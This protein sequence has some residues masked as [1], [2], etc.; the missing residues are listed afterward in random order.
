MKVADTCDIGL[1]DL[2]PIPCSQENN[3]NLE[4][5][6]KVLQDEPRLEEIEDASDI[7]SDLSIH[8]EI[9]NA[10]SWRR[11]SC[12]KSS[13][14]I[15]SQIDEFAN[16]EK[17]TPL[18]G[19][20]INLDGPEL[21]S[22][23]VKV[24]STFIVS[25]QENKNLGNG[26][27]NVLEPPRPTNEHEIMD[28]LF[29]GRNESE[30]ACDNLGVIDEIFSTKGASCCSQS[31]NRDEN[32]DSP[33]LSMLLSRTNS[34]PA[35]VGTGNNEASTEESQSRAGKQDSMG[36]SFLLAT[37]DSDICNTSDSSLEP[38]VVQTDTEVCDNIN[39]SSDQSNQVLLN[40]VASEVSPSRRSSVLAPVGVTFLQE[41]AKTNSIKQDL[42]QVTKM[43]FTRKSLID[44]NISKL[45]LYNS[46]KSKQARSSEMRQSNGDV[47]HFRRSS[48]FFP[49]NNSSMQ[50]ISEVETDLFV[51]SLTPFS[52]DISKARKE[53]SVDVQNNENESPRQSLRINSCSVGI[54]IDNTLTEVSGVN[55]TRD[56]LRPRSKS[57]SSFRSRSNI[58]QRNSSLSE[59]RT[60]KSGL[61][62]NVSIPE[63]NEIQTRK[64]NGEEISVGLSITKSARSLSSENA[65]SRTTN[66][67]RNSA[68]SLFAPS[69]LSIRANSEAFDAANVFA[70]QQVVNECSKSE[71]IGLFDGN[72]SKPS[73]ISNFLEEFSRSNIFE[74]SIRTNK[75]ERAVAR[76][77]SVVRKVSEATIKEASELQ[78]SGL[79]GTEGRVSLSFSRNDISSSEDARRS[80]SILSGF[81]S[82]TEVVAK[83]KPAAQPEKS[84][85]CSGSS[86][87][88]DKSVSNDTFIRR[89]INDTL[90]SRSSH[91]AE[92]SYSGLV[93]NHGSENTASPG[94][95]ESGDTHGTRNSSRST[96]SSSR[97]N[98]ASRSSGRSNSTQSQLKSFS[99]IGKGISRTPSNK[100]QNEESSLH[101]SDTNKSSLESSVFGYSSEQSVKSR[102]D[103]NV[104]QTSSKESLKESQEIENIGS[105][106]LDSTE[107]S[108]NVSQSTRSRKQVI[109]PSY[110]LPSLDSGLE[111][112]KR[113]IKSSSL[114]DQPDKS[115]LKRKSNRSEES[116]ERISQRKSRRSKSS[117]SGQGY[118][119][120]AVSIISKRKNLTKKDRSSA[121]SLFD[122][123][124]ANKTAEKSQF[125]NEL[126][127]SREFEYSIRANGN[128]RVAKT[129][130][131]VTN[132]ISVDSK[133]TSEIQLSDV[134]GTRER[135]S[136]RN[137][138]KAFDCHV[139]PYAL[140]VSDM[141]NVTENNLANEADICEMQPDEKSR[142]QTTSVQMLQNSAVEVMAAGNVDSGCQNETATGSDGKPI[143]FSDLS[144][145]SA[146]S[147]RKEI[148]ATAEKIIQSEDPT[149]KSDK[150]IRAF[151]E[152]DVTGG[153]NCV[154]KENLF[155]DPF[156][157]DTNSVTAVTVLSQQN[158]S[159]KTPTSIPLRSTKRSRRSVSFA[160]TP[161][162]QQDP[163]TS[164]NEEPKGVSCQVSFRKPTP[165]KRLSRK[166]VGLQTTVRRRMSFIRREDFDRHENVETQVGSSLYYPRKSEVTTIFR[167]LSFGNHT[168]R[169]PG[170]LTNTNEK[171]QTTL[172]REENINKEL[173][174]IQSAPEKTGNE[175]AFGFENQQNRSFSDGKSSASKSQD[176]IRSSKRGLVPRKY[177]GV[178]ASFA[179]KSN[180]KLMEK[181]KRKRALSKDKERI[182]A[183]RGCTAQEPLPPSTT[184][185]TT[186][187]S[188]LLS[189][190]RT[191]INSTNYLAG[192]ENT[193][194]I[195]TKSKQIH[196]KATKQN[197]TKTIAKG[198]KRTKKYDRKLGQDGSAM[199][200][201]NHG[202]IG[203]NHCVNDLEDYSRFFAELR[204]RSPAKWPNGSPVNSTKININSA[205]GKQETDEQKRSKGVYYSFVRN[206]QKYHGK[207][208]VIASFLF[209]II[210]TTSRREEE[211]W[212]RV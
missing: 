60:R 207:C 126:S 13:N 155:V 114:S 27:N 125:L 148:N 40:P 156:C 132:N 104:E 200:H 92:R 37:G 25:S 99:E 147:E 151:I 172:R 174:R 176:S 23:L 130:N 102:E 211:L 79:N 20:E 70:D 182:E 183:K 98:V 66:G 51:D 63:S 78:L 46:S 77:G 157:F 86:N 121:I 115:S 162:E 97:S 166:S 164:A 73:E 208:M 201:E 15:S 84:E 210:P 112:S 142:S 58:G 124:A 75:N 39:E 146:E 199:D 81:E 186:E 94:K 43:D 190:S 76:K 144:E 1:L 143:R 21:N 24:N 93:E 65:K 129:A 19:K 32:C 135:F 203:D 17:Q 54:S 26:S 2:S 106:N 48:N 9:T 150:V 96:A 85:E 64:S 42:T 165:H 158:S 110:T 154:N 139:N 195:E 138:F 209:R 167:Y 69:S 30:N 163:Q 184:I 7:S 127:N 11:R 82:L 28:G 111:Q 134:N 191:N 53:K 188:D 159:N 34:D 4:C 187:T 212:R 109:E 74:N 95:T 50:N 117:E 101:F 141:E 6:N 36:P 83:D 62:A 178:I 153:S 55:R 80:D 33:G 149:E 68:L 57:K 16:D 91:R 140:M 89:N 45:S 18:D 169:N 10:T 137:S 14:N 189:V 131:A 173:P 193:R 8:T 196:D 206:G 3:P 179:I 88:S 108:Q 161:E 123:D 100:L 128:V 197:A 38:T 105:P 5:Q 116:L 122:V 71:S 198:M 119:A 31:Q 29:D 204:Q 202:N 49:V 170:E 103:E 113:A 107:Y 160:V 177:P 185:T 180:S 41:S 52:T 133:N 22:T 61:Q 205:P 152:K 181:S 72:N 90:R 168:E 47:S 35:E 12:D 194:G 87:F 67:D 175:K 56:I 145:E 171:E 136:R 118:R 120:S 59:T 192:D 44:G